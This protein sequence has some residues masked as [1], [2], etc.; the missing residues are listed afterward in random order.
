MDNFEFA[1]AR[2]ETKRG[3]KHTD[4]DFNTNKSTTIYDDLIRRDLTINSMALDV[5]TNELIDPFDGKSDIK[6][7]ILKG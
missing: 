6:N 4:F 1:L 3:I 2:T 7:K 5:L